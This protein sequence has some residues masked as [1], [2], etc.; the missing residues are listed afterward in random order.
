MIL[1]ASYGTDTVSTWPCQGTL[2][3]WTSPG[4]GVGWH[5][6]ANLNISCQSYLFCEW[7]N[8]QVDLGFDGPPF[9]VEVSIKRTGDFDVDGC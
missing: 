8:D 3:S 2:V 5:G 6:S 4:C 1:H 7:G 9:S